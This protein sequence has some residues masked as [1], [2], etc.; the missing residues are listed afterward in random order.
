VLDLDAA[1]ML[2]IEIPDKPGLKL[3]VL[4]VD[5]G[6]DG[7]TL[8]KRVEPSRPVIHRER[9][10]VFSR[11]QRPNHSVTCSV[12]GGD[13]VSVN[14][15]HIDSICFGIDDDPLRSIT[16]GDCPVVWTNTRFRMLYINIGHED[17][18]FA[19]SAQNKL[20]EDA[21]LWLGARSKVRIK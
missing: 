19:S 20:F 1:D 10:G 8:K 12:D 16:G 4:E 2:S 9:I 7:L 15:C 21:I 3:S 6:D 14:V 5:Y 18:I 13:A 11:A 17:E